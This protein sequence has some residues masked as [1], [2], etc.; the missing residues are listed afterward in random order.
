[1]KEILIYVE[2]LR[3]VNGVYTWLMSFYNT[4][5]DDYE[6]TIM[7]DDQ[8]RRF[9]YRFENFQFYDKT[10]T[11]VTDIFINSYSWK[12]A[13]KNV[14]CKQAYTML[15]CDYGGID[16]KIPPSFYA[17]EHYIAV[18]RYAAENF[19]RKFGLPCNYVEGLLIPQIQTKPKSVHQGLR[20]IS[21]TRLQPKKGD[22]RMRQLCTLLDANGVDYIWDNYCGDNLLRKN[23]IPCHNQIPQTELFQYIAD[24]DYLV[25]LS[26]TEGYCRSVHEALMVGTPVIV[27]DIPIFRDVVKNGINGYRVPLDITRIT[28]LQ[29]IITRIPKDFKSEDTYTA[30]R[31]RWL[32][33]W[34][35]HKEW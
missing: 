33:I 15:H 21:C 18:S 16:Y 31:Q 17:N 1:M 27:C 20:L 32:S 12:P 2:Y 9:M 3:W 26:E 5:K 10:A 30:T 28:N 11:Y 25:Q 6:I 4:F 22:K 7:T 13:P 24:A 23:F 19:T 14:K 35:E 8:S 34:K 29:E